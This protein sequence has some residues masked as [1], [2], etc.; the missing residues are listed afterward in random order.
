MGQ[1]LLEKKTLVRVSITLENGREDH[2]T[3]SS[4]FMFLKN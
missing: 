1:A 3:I 4:V 2:M